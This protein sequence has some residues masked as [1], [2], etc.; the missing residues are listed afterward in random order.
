MST[1]EGTERWG[2]FLGSVHIA[3]PLVLCSQLCGRSHFHREDMRMKGI[4]EDVSCATVPDLHVQG[5]SLVG[6]E[7]P[8]ER[9]WY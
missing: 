4:R 5:V 8:S 6:F 3:V 1:A 9:R 7:R 2:V